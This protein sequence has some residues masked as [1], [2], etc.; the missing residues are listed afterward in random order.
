MLLKELQAR[1][2]IWYGESLRPHSPI[3][4]KTYVH[5]PTTPWSMCWTSPLKLE[6]SVIAIQRLD[7]EAAIL[8]LRAT[9]GRFH[10]YCLYLQVGT[11]MADGLTPISVSLRVCTKCVS[12]S[13]T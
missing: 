10:R 3:V 6:L 2:I 12:V 8:R 11:N 9:T 7:V 4:E 5:I 13:R 1:G